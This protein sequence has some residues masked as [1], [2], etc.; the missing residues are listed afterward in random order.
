[1][2]YV[3]MDNYIFVAKEFQ[4]EKGMFL[5]LIQLYLK[6]MVK[7]L[8]VNPNVDCFFSYYHLMGCIYSYV[9]DIHSMVTLA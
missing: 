9:L 5:I 8:M 4:T 6:K 1:M 7:T 3:V 2:N